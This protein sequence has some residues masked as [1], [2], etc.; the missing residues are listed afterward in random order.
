MTDPILTGI[1]AD[2]NKVKA[3]WTRWEVYVIAAVCLIVGIIVGHK[4]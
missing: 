2:L 3:L 4:I 1:S